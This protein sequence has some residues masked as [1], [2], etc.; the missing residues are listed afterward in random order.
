M[1][2]LLVEILLCARYILNINE[3]IE[4]TLEHWGKC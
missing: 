2:H 1:K 3:K 4:W